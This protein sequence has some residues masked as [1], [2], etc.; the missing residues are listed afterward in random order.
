M[1]GTII[2]G[3]GGLYFVKDSEG[4]VLECRARGLFRKDGIKPMI[5]DRVIVRNGSIAE[6][7]PRKN[8]LIRPPVSNIDNLVIVAAAASPDPNYLLIDKMLVNA[9]IA[10]ISPII[11][12][13][14]TDLA[15]GEK[16]EAIYALSGYPVVSVCAE[17]N[18]GIAELM[19]YLK[20]KTT[21]FSGLSGVGKSTILNILTGS[22][23]ET[24]DISDKIQR[25]RHTTRHVELLELSGGG[26]VLDTPGFGSL[27]VTETRAEELA[28]FFPEFETEGCRFKDCSHINEPGCAVKEK[29]ESGK[30]ALSRYE[31]YCSIYESLKKMKD[32]EK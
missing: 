11:C 29:L 3:I 5:G 13:N 18:D 31:S 21:A 1:T 17:K 10:G 19:P 26:Y 14:K 23:M 4:G 7:E 9:E 6:I 16:T 28:S 22:E 2:K 20:G 27:E 32:W 24:G 25:G 30:I 12:I 15:S 8:F